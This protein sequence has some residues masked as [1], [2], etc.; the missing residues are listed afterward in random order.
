M[1]ESAPWQLIFTVGLIVGC[2]IGI[3][4]SHDK[5]SHDGIIHVTQGE[6]SDKYLFE[7]NIPPE[8]IPRMK[9]VIFEVRVED[10]QNLQTLR[11]Q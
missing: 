9:N 7:F 11:G 3:L 10:E 6:E 1:I 8:E 2:L 5:K 4:L